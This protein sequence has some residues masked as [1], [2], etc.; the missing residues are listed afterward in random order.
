[1]FDGDEAAQE[2][3]AEFRCEGEAGQDPDWDG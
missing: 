1:V 2:E 3:A